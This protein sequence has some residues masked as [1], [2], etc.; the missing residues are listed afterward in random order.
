MRHKSFTDASGPQMTDPVREDD[1]LQAFMPT[2][3]S[4][5]KKAIGV[6]L[7]K[8]FL[9]AS[10]FSP[11]PWSGDQSIQTL[12]KALADQYHWQPEWQGDDITALMRDGDLISIEPGG[13]I[14]LSCRQETTLDRAHAVELNHL[15][16][17][18][19]IARYAI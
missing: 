19:S 5:N 6:E 16:E 3:A 7:E 14:E 1:L 12:L 10:D 18:K 11:L 17:I 15:R 13:Q 9:K 2:S 8:F 4:Q